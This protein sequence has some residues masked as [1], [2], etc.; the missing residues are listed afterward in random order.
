MGQSRWTV[1]IIAIIGASVSLI[2]FYTARNWE[3]N[4]IHEV[5]N[6]ISD[7]RALVFENAIESNLESILSLNAFYEASQFVSREEF[8][9]FA[10][11]EIEHHTSI[12]ALEWIPRVPEDKR[13]VYETKARHEGLP[14]FRITEMKAQGNMVPAGRR[15]EYFPV[16]YVEP[17]RGNEAAIGFDLA[18]NPTRLETLKK[19]RDSGEMSATARIL[20]VQETSK[21]Y[22]FLVFQPVYSGN[23]ATVNER[24]ENLLGYV[25]GAFR[26]GDI[27]ENAMRSKIEIGTEIR[28]ELF[29]E[30]SPAKDI[31]LNISVTKPVVDSFMHRTTVAVAGRT[32]S[33]VSWPTD[34]FISSR[35]SLQIY[36]ILVS[37]FLLTGALSA[38]VWFQERHHADL[39]FT[40]QERTRDARKALDDVEKAKERIDGILK[41]VSDGLIVTD[42][43]NNIILMNRAAENLLNIQFND[44]INQPIDLAIEDKTLREKVIETLGKKT[45]GYEFNFKL[46][47]NIPGNPKIMRGSTAVI[48]DKEGKQTGIVT[49]LH[50]ITRER[51]VDRMKTEFISTAA[52]ELR[53]P[54]TSI[55]G[56]S[57]ILTTRDN[58]NLEERS[59]FLGYINKQAAGLER[60]IN[61][62]LDISRLESGGGY[63]LDKVPCIAGDEIKQILPFFEEITKTHRFELECPPNDVHIFVDKDKM[64]QTLKNIISNAVK[65]SP[66]GGLIRITCEIKG[67]DYQISVKDSGIGMTKEQ[68]GKVFDKFYRVDS[69][70]TAAEGT[71]LGMSIVKYIIEAHGGK[72]WVESE[73]GKSTTV[74]F[75]LP[76]GT[77]KGD[78]SG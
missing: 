46:P 70:D 71:G 57:E 39:E 21:Q 19:A 27:F 77:S 24:R 33:M 63:K 17:L 41:S 51:E 72:I 38:F 75:R 65:Y 20:P 37:G 34:D 7:D 30:S 6:E 14:E 9:I 23:P 1:W 68:L 58:L 22:G 76:I 31:L 67:N 54:L 25:L 3:L 64:G 53:T 12:Q 50:D 43:H 32:W 36:I 78:K 13:E 42:I 52:H 47:T 16:Y 73:Y 4:N 55:L 10:G 44:V 5:F 59:K 61:D 15:P 40:V 49:I 2:A 62:L 69:S 66:D 18:S 48:L 8:K 35:R 26:I 60:I 74:R 28:T 45:A 11:T 56:F 29:D